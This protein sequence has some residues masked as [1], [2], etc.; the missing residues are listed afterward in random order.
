MLICSTS[1]PHPFPSDKVVKGGIEDM[2]VWVDA[3]GNYHCLFHLMYGCGNCGSHAYSAD[4]L[5]WTYTGVAYTAETNFTD[6]GTTVRG[7]R[8]VLRWS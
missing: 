3:R 5:R 2:F 8:V 6:G 4:G 1:A 7:P